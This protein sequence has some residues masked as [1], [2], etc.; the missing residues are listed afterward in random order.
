MLLT[1]LATALISIAVSFGLAAL[2]L[3]GA[4]DRPS[5]DISQAVEVVYEPFIVPA[6][7]PAQREARCPRGMGATGGGA[8]S[9][10][11]TSTLLVLD[12]LPG[13]VSPDAAAGLPPSWRVRVANKSFTEV[14]A[15]VV[16]VCVALSAPPRD[17]A[18]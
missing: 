13:R 11:V 16:A 18:R 12:S 10:A 4:G 5:A 7:G 15:G 3:D 14:R 2:L 1:L 17:A 9:N 8:Y 6:R